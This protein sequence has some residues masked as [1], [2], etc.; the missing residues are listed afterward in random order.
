[1]TTTMTSVSMACPAK[2]N[3]FLRILAREDS[4]YHQIET[5]FQ[6][7]GLFDRVDVRAGPPGISLSVHRTAPAPGAGMK[8]RVTALT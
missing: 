6:A 3:L 8:V 7:V 2:V 1:M 5:L 4:G